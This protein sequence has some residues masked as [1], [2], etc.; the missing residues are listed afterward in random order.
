MS[1]RTS[2]LFGGENPE[3]HDDHYDNPLLTKKI[4]SEP[5]I[6]DIGDEEEEYPFVNKYPSFKKN[7]SWCEMEP[8]VFFGVDMVASNPNPNGWTWVF[9]TNNKQH[10]KPID[11]PFVKDMENIAMSFYVSN[12]PNS[13]DAKNLWKEF[14]PS[15]RI[16]DA[17]IAN[18]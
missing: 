11:D 13:L 9:G 7:L 5:I 4:E 3:F 16:V 17:F 18:K 12:F 15:R 2:I 6:W 8:Y 1:Q 14:Q 10:S